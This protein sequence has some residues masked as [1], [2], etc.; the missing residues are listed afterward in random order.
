[1][2]APTLPNGFRAARDDDFPATGE[3]IALGPHEEL[4][5]LVR[6]GRMTPVPD[7]PYTGP[8]TGDQLDSLAVLEALGETQRLDDAPVPSPFLHRGVFRTGIHRVSR[9]AVALGLILAVQAAL[10]LRLIWSNTAFSDEA[11]YIWAGHL[12]WGNWLHGTPTPTF[13]TYFSGAPVV[14]PPVAALADSVGGLAG[15]RLLSL[16]LMLSATC[17]SYDVTRRLFDRRSGV[18]A[19]AL[20]AGLAAT[21]Y[22]G[23]FATYDAMALSLLAL[24]TW[25]L[26]LHASARSLAARAT[27]LALATAALALADASKYAAILFDPIV[28]AVAAFAVCRWRG[29]ASGIRAGLAFG[30]AIAVLLVAGMRIGGETYWEGFTS[31]TLSRTHGTFSAFGILYVSAGWVG[32]VAALA[33]IGAVVVTVTSKSVSMRLLAV[34]LAFAPLLPPVEQARIG[35]FTS[36]FKHVGFGAWFGSIV[37]AYALTSLPRAVPGPKRRRALATG[38]AMLPLAAVP[39]LLLAGAHFRNWPDEGAV[40]PVLTAAIRQH[41]GP[42]LSEDGPV[43]DYYLTGVEPW[44]DITPVHDGISPARYK[45]EISA[46]TFSVIFESLDGAGDGCTQDGTLNGAPVCTSP[47]DVAILADIKHSGRYR[48]VASLPYATSSFRSS[49][50]IWERT[51]GAR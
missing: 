8:V 3:Q 18:F 31:T 6:R 41:P 5:E 15:A 14:Y 37:A 11:L 46:G 39:G 34:T 1:V 9:S 12:E 44:R 25:L 47:L 20:F 19:G 30:T 50:L 43:N 27:L 2:S 24:S 22:L 48:L 49:F 51:G 4:A 26:I 23:A 35:V 32:Q 36:L 17:L 38:A 29:R 21:Q 42:V 28:I 45:Q 7:V 10:S 13:A 33:A 40:L 16:L